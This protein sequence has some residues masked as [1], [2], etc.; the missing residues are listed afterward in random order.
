[1]RVAGCLLLLS[2][3]IICSCTSDLENSI[4]PPTFSIKVA[5]IMDGYDSTNDHAVVGLVALSGGGGVGI[6]SGSLIAPNVVLTAQHCVAPLSNGNGT[7]DC[8]TTTFG[9]PY[10]DGTLYVSTRPQLSYNPGDYHGSMDVLIPP[11][12]NGVCGRDIALLV[13][14]NPVPATE[15]V[16]LTPRVDSP[17]LDPNDP[18]QIV[19]EVYS[20]IGYGN[21]SQWGGGSGERRRRDNLHVACAGPECIMYGLEKEFLGD[22]GVCQGDSGGPAVDDVGRVT[23]VASRG[24][25]GCQY[26]VYSAVYDWR[27]WLM[28]SVKTATQNAGLEPPA[29][30]LGGSTHPGTKYSMGEPCSNGQGCESGLCLDG[31]CARLCDD[32][33]PCPLGFSCVP[34]E[35]GTAPHDGS[36]CRILPIGDTCA[37]SADCLYPGL[38]LEG[39]CT[40]DCY[41]D[42]GCPPPYLCNEAVDMCLLPAV[43]ASCSA[44]TDC[45]SGQCL[46]GLCT[47]DCDDSM[48]CPE[49]Y[50]CTA[51]GLCELPAMGGSCETA[52][53]CESGLCVDGICTRPCG[54]DAPCDE[55]TI[56]NPDSG[57]CAPSPAGNACNDAT[58]CM[59]L[60][61]L[62]GQCAAACDDSQPCASG[63]VCGSS[64]VCER[65]E[66]GSSGG[67]CQ[68]M[69]TSTATP[70]VWLLLAMVLA[71]L[72]FRRR[73]HLLELATA[74][75]RTNRPL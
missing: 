22:T 14:E 68:L 39:I 53:S 11:G 7:V 69:A 10:D 28:E 43:G 12:G 74:V 6:C 44:G 19:G 62:D 45:P 5:P 25:Q 32:Y 46:D 21:T 31:Y 17:M 55:D 13:L 60:A 1:M 9:A 23:G 50:Q 34:V 54:D 2:S 52:D 71:L 56:C 66:S 75:V 49:P 57:L 61:C 40:R 63:S 36:Y 58:D 26:P 29:W 18:G 3:L 48:P 70:S 73:A 64:G 59:G 16:P 65:V 24:G 20:A 35:P 38:C 27:E 30:T 37:S 51:D 72:S 47:R 42:I 15:A 8:T 4:S 67:G 33:A 41:G